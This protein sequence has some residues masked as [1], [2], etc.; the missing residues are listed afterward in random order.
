MAIMS[1][2]KYGDHSYTLFGGILTLMFYRRPTY[3]VIILL[4]LKSVVGGDHS[5]QVP[6]GLT[7][8]SFGC[9]SFGVGMLEDLDQLWFGYGL[10]LGWQ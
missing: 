9:D 5:R 6:S 4:S 2:A 7:L 1:L 8:T 3:C 10:H